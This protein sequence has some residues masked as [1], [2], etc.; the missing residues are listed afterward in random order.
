[1]QADKGV[2]P[3]RVQFFGPSIP[4]PQFLNLPKRLGVIFAILYRPYLHMSPSQ[5]QCGRNP[6]GFPP[7]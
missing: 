1:M 3:S 4:L 6:H 7:I 5:R 2:S